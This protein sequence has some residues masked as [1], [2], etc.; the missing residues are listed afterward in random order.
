MA[1]N[2]VRSLIT[3]T[4]A[5][6]DY[7]DR[8]MMIAQGDLPDIF[9]NI[10]TGRTASLARG[11]ALLVRIL[12]HNATGN[13]RQVD[14]VLG[15]DPF[16]SPAAGAFFFNDN[17]QA[18]GSHDDRIEGAGFGTGPQPQAADGTDFHAAAQQRHRSTVIQAIINIFRSGIVH[19]EITAGPGDIRLFGLDFD[20]HNFGNGFRHFST[21]RH[22]RVGGGDTGHDRFGIGAATRQ[23]TTASVGTR[24]SVFNR[25]D[26]GIDVHIKN[27]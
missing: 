22:T 9:T 11:R 25:L 10:D 5:F 18:L 13:G 23:P 1:G 19:P 14:D 2:G 27:L 12:P 16:A 8:T 4:A 21:G 20:P 26:L 15:A 24:Q 3:W 17:G 7:L 6:L